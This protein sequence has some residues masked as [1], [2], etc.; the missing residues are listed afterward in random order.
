MSSFPPYANR[1]FGSDDGRRGPPRHRRAYPSWARAYL[2]RRGV[3]ARAHAARHQR[4]AAVRAD[5]QRRIRAAAGVRERRR[6]RP[7]PLDVAVAPLAKRGDDRVEVRA[8]LGQ[9][10]LEPRGGLPVL[11]AL[12]DAP[13]HQLLDPRGGDSARGAG[14]ALEL[15]EPV[16]AEEGLADHEQRPSVADDVKRASDRADA[17]PVVHGERVAQWVVFSNSLPYAPAL[18]V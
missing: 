7:G 10:V 16:G 14:L 17:G 8:R 12:E 13:P 18:S 5:E 2:R 11:P 3:R 6:G 1:G 4:L 9:V 15:V